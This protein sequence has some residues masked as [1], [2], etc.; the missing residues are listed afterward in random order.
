MTTDTTTA[1]IP[2]LTITE[3]PV[4][5]KADYPA[6]YYAFPS[7]T[8][9]GAYP[10]AGLVDLNV[11]SSQPSW[12]TSITQVIALTQD[13]WLSLAPGNLIIKEGKVAAYTEPT[14]TTS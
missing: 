12:L 10:V 2:T 4:W 6:Q 5:W 8:M 1:D 9:L 11:Y 13:E 3:T 14:I 7:S